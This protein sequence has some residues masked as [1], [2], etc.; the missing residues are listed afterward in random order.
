MGIQIA[1]IIDK[2][3]EDYEWW[4]TFTRGNRCSFKWRFYT[5]RNNFWNW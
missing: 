5:K 2:D 3:V 1:E 4:T